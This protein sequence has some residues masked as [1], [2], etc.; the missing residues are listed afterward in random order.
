MKNPDCTLDELMQSIKGPDFPTG[1][2]IMGRSGIRA[3]YG[4]GRGKI[5]LRSKTSIE[6]IKGRNCII[7]T[8]IPYMVNKARL[9]ESIADLVKEKRIDGIHY[10][11]DESG[12]DGMRI[13][14]E[15]KKDANPQVVL[16]KLF[17]YTQLQDTVG[18]IMLAL[19]NGIPKVLTLKEMLEQYIDFQVDVITRRTKFDLNKAKERE[20]ILKGLV[21]ALDNI[22]EVIEIMKTSKN[23]PEAK[24]R[25]NQ[26]F[27]LTDI[28][29]DHIANMTLG[30][31]TGMERQKIIDE[32][33][34]IEVK[35]ADLEDI[36]AN[37]QRIL[38][39]IIEEVE[40]I[41]DKFGDERRTQI[42]NVS[43]EVDIEDLIPVE[44]S[45][46]T[47]T[48]AGY[49]KRM[50]VSE[51][52]AQK[53]GGRGVTGMKQREDDYIDELQTCSSHDNI[54]FI[55]NKGIMYKLKCYELPEGSKA[56]RGTNIVN[57]LELGAG[58][59]IAAMIKT[60][61]FDEGKYIVMVTKNGKR[62][63]TPL[64]SYRN[65]RKNGLIA[66]GL[67]EGD[68]I[69]GVRMTF[70]DNEVIVATH[71]GYAI[72]IRETDIREMSRVAHGVKAIKLR[73]ST[74]AENGLGRRVPLESYKVQ[75][76]G[77]Y[78]LMNYKSGGVC[79]IKVVDDEDDIIMISTDGIVIRIRACDI[80]MM[81]RYSRGVRL[82]RVGE[83]GRVVSFTRTEHDDDVETAEVEKAT[84]EEIAEAQ[85]EE[86]AEVIEDNTESVE[87]EDSENTEE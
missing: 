50:P 57:L 41:Q 17:S 12:K 31:L 13:V 82:M 30:R 26:R 45:V 62:K 61:D 33:A 55:S 16:N 84:A 4:T 19:V 77:G 42:E 5:T 52:K 11:N 34:E 81:S 75:N 68:E 48:N 29:A 38:D 73:G 1:G 58:E 46:V 2:I 70:G 80:S 28:Q 49:I 54:L 21:I 15:L 86:N 20:H 3:A 71:N 51:Y 8:E 7:V 35:I 40:A 65:V 44:E 66:I 59:K 76:R 69:A 63:R 23:I 18:V 85:A 78:G 64:T 36:L 79:G 6:E 9:V 72:R 24:Q 60:A 87:N 32:L 27:G 47:Y 10:I 53:R 67:D 25:L 37:H 83:D 74:V 39:I 43:G 56:S 22:D 14:I